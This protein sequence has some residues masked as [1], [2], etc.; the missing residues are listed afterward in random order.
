MIYGILYIN[1]AC[2]AFR[3]EPYHK[4][5][6]LFPLKY[7]TLGSKYPWCPRDNT[8]WCNSTGADNAQK[9]YHQYQVMIK[10]EKVYPHISLLPCYV[11]GTVINQV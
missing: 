6:I 8:A 4:D 7:E 10:F 11:A 5:P 3:M 1:T 9:D 2:N